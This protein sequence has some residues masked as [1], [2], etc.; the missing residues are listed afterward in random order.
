M[1]PK[2]KKGTKNSDF[3][4]IDS[5][6]EITPIG[7]GQTSDDTGVSRIEPLFQDSPM[8]PEIPQANEWTAPLQDEPLAPDPFASA[9]MT[10]MAPAAND[11]TA[12]GVSNVK[13]A[14]AG[15]NFEVQADLMKAQVDSISRLASSEAVSGNQIDVLRKYISLKEAEAKDLKEQLRQTQ[16]LLQKMTSEMGRAT[17]AITDRNSNVDSLK[18]ER[19]HLRKELQEIKDRYKGDLSQVRAEME[20][21]LRSTGK[22]D[23]DVEALYRQKEEWKEK[24]KDDLKKIK[25]KER[26]IET[27]HELLKRDMQ[28]LLDSKDKHLLELRKKCDALEF[29]QENLEDRLRKATF[30]LS[31]IDS[32]K[33]RLI[34][35]MRLAISLLEKVDSTDEYSSDDERKAG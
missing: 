10:P 18:S 28:A 31:S 6:G 2:S 16:G 32:K 14:K 7:G 12:T 26:E 21:K 30:V 19:D 5:E 29:E 3:F 23:S 11:N 34:E 9:P 17:S 33:K 4:R 24:I 15:A 1:D 13:P 35:T 20:E 25:L 22:L 27:K 8:M